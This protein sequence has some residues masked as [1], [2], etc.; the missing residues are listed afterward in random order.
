[1]TPRLTNGTLDLVVTRNGEVTNVEIVFINCG[2]Y[3]V[4]KTPSGAA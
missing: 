3:Q 1:V 4:T 2:Q